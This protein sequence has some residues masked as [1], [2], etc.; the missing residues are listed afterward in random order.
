MTI[1]SAQY[2]EDSQLRNKWVLSPAGLC[3][4]TNRGQ[5]AETFIQVVVKW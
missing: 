5:W 1:S 2:R 4:K 3:D